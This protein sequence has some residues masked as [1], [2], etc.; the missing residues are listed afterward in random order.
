FDVDEALE[1]SGIDYLLV[2]SPPP[3]TARKGADYTYQLVVKS[4]KGGVRYRLDSGPAGMTIG[5]DGKLTWSVPAARAQGDPSV[6]VTVSDATGQECVHS[7]T[8]SVRG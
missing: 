8:L 3:L 7:F 2:T 4:K 5:T 1:K 6:I